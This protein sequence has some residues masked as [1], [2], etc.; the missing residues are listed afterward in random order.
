MP[1]GKYVMNVL[2][3]L[4]Q[5]ANT[6]TGGY[7]DETISSR[8]GKALKL[9]KTWARWLC[10]GLDKIDPGHCKDAIETDEGEQD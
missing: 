5:F 7:P 6:W 1:F 2:I 4:D 10:W 9:D 3:G 8:A